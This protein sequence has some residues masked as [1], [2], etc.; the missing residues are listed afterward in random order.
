MIEDHRPEAEAMPQV[1][2]P[3]ESTTRRR[4]RDVQVV[5]TQSDAQRVI[6]TMLVGFPSG[7]RAQ[8]R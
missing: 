5:H 2:R 8:W 1:A 6:L 3:D 7:Q 4:P